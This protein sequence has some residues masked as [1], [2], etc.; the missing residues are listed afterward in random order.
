MNSRINWQQF[1][2]LFCVQGLALLMAGTGRAA[3]AATIDIKDTNYSIPS[4]AYFVAPDGKDTNSGKA[5][6]SPWPVA[7]A[8]SSAPNRATIVFRGGTYRNIDNVKIP[9]QLTLQ[10]YPHEKPWLKGSLIVTG[11]VADGSI[12]RKDGW[13]YS[14]PQNMDKV[15][16][17]PKYPLAGYRDMVYV[18]GTYLKQVSSKAKVVSGT[19]YVDSGGNKLYIGTNPVGKTVEATTKD[20]A[21]FLQRMGSFNPS[22]TV[23]RGLGFAHYADQAMKVW[24][25]NV[26]LENNAFVWNGVEGVRLGG[27]C[28]DAI[29]RGNSFSYNGRK[30]LSGSHAHRMYL[31]GNTISYNNI[32]QFELTWDAAGIK[33]IK[34]D[35]LIWR[36]N[37]VEHNMATGMWVDES[38]TNAT[39]VNNTSRYNGEFG[40]FF[41]ISHKAIIAANIAYYN[42]FAGVAMSNSSSARVYNNTLVN[43]GKGLRVKDTKRNNTNTAE[44]AKGITWVARNNV[45][46][47]NIISNARGG[48]LFDASICGTSKS[49]APMFAAADYNAYYRSSASKPKVA[50]SWSLN[51][52]KCSVSYSTLNAFKS[53]TGY[54]TH[55]LNFDNVATNPFFVN[56]AKGDYRLK[57]GSPAIGRGEPLPADIA[58]A[59][60]L[61]SGVPVDMGA[62]Q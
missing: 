49:S 19:F 27:P 25:P 54:E 61:P 50:V 38:S 8:I 28:S 21:F 20:E 55:S 57:S 4:G 17:N 59:I 60:G 14:F 6:N 5:P 31:D 41:E 29:I 26:T 48:S 24:A 9:K 32:E 51:A 34:T 16:I 40:I 53:A 43:N 52:S 47:N 62:L 18:N 2:I 3:A 23:V 13:N 1:K 33:V 22:G 46:K 37:L 44:V 56:E 7:K 30:G 42:K 45:L 11:W 12:W 35:G 10:A 58:K 39:I 15:Y 36:N